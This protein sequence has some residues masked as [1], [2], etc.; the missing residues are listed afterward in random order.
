MGGPP[1]LG[2]TIGHFRVVEHIGAGGMGSVYVGLDERLDR[3]VALK[4]LREEQRLSPESRSRFL[5]E[6]RILSQLQHPNICQIHDY[7]EAD[8][9]DIL[10]LELVEGESLRRVIERRPGRSL[11][12]D[13]AEQIAQALIAAHEKD[14]VHRD[15]KPGNVV[16]TPQGRVKL[17]DFG[18]ARSLHVSWPLASPE[19]SRAPVSGGPGPGDAAPASR[20][21]TIRGE[22]P[23][24]QGLTVTIDPAAEA[25]RPTASLGRTV[26]EA[27]PTRSDTKIGMVMGTLSYMS[28]EQARGEPVTAATD[29]YSYGLLLQE[30]FTGEP[31]YQPN[32]ALAEQLARASRGE[33]VP[34]D[35]RVG[36]DL[37]A[38]VDRLKAMAP[39]ARP[40]AAEAARQIRWIRDTPR[41]RLKRAAA[42]GAF[43]LLALVAGGMSYQAYRISQANQR[44]SREAEV[45]RQVSDFLVGLFEV[46]DPSQSRGNTITAREI[47]DQGARRIEVS[48]RSQPLTQA[49]LMDVMGVVYRELGLYDEAGRLLRSARDTRLRLLGEDHRDVA[50]SLSNLALVFREQGD[51]AQA[52]PLFERSLEIQRKTSAAD[53]PDVAKALNLLAGNHQLTGD[54]DKAE[55]L[56]S[57]A[58]GIYDRAGLENADLGDLLASLGLLY[59]TKGDP[60][61]AEKVLERAIA[62]DEKVLGPDHPTVT[63][64]LNNLALVFDQTAEFERSKA[65]YERALAI[66]EKVQGKDHPAVAQVLNNLA[67]NAVRRDDYG[68]ARSRFERVLQIQ[69]KALGP[70][71]PDLATA[72]ANLA[73]VCSAVG[74]YDRAESL[75][76]RALAIK[77]KTLGPDNPGTAAAVGIL[78]NLHLARGAY[79]RAEVLFRRALAIDEKSL[80]PDHPDVALDLSNLGTALWYQGKLALAEPLLRRALEVEQK[81]PTTGNVNTRNNLAGLCVE[82]GKLDEARALYERSIAVSEERLSRNEPGRPARGGLVTALLGLGNVR[83]LQGDRP[84]AVAS[85]TRALTIAEE[86]ATGREIVVYLDRYAKALL[87]LGR[88]EDARPLVEKL[89]QKGWTNP[90][91]HQLCRANGLQL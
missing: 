60:A 90:T 46:S 85:W 22:G 61:R 66:R 50:A 39:G 38:L 29:M 62:V 43:V 19:P 47:L 69:E 79:P 26:S 41:R 63:T 15:L 13:I 74:D 51:Y 14:I 52:R 64:A 30:L 91:L 68:Q 12:L 65:L 86:L 75:V 2:T 87:Y 45:A 18:L 1:L 78:A 59:L 83:R 67:I 7:V 21:V 34:I 55:R 24:V 76:G 32:L 4:V 54:Y 88:V 6:A 23:V 49:R 56:Y 16:L 8:G 71:H 20:T 37:V 48:L 27:S 81:A 89:R 80:G 5:R 9:R 35:P 82:Q 36:P 44:A 73:F 10:V 72:L 58:L 77:E 53:G 70:A 25:P 17:L 11:C 33:T 84:D 28:P 57:E 31:P 3:R 40:T 42:V